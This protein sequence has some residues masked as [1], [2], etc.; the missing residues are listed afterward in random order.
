MSHFLYMKSKGFCSLAALLRKKRSVLI[1]EIQAEMRINTTNSSAA[2]NVKN[3]TF[4]AF[5]LQISSLKALERMKLCLNRFNPHDCRVQE[6]NTVKLSLY[7]NLISMFSF[8]VPLPRQYKFFIFENN[9]SALDC[10]NGTC[11][12]IPS[13]TKIKTI[14]CRLCFFYKSRLI[15]AFKCIIGPQS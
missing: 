9:K 4:V 6:Q 7:T 13:S 14:I 15:L 3:W 12:P 2:Y 1:Y 10:T 8:L 11:L 5:E